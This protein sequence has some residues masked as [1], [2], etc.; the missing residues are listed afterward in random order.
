MRGRPEGVREFG[1]RRAGPAIST[2]DCY[3]KGAEGKRQGDLDVAQYLVTGF[4][5]GCSYALVGV[6]FTIIYKSY[7]ILNFAQ[8][9]FA[10]F[11]AL[12][13]AWLVTIKGVSTAVAIA[14]GLLLVAGLAVVFEVGLL[15]PLKGREGPAIIVTIAAGVL[16]TGVAGLVFGK[17]SYILPAMLP[18]EH[19]IVVLGATVVVQQVIVVLVAGVTLVLVAVFFSQTLIG[20]AMTASVDDPGLALLAGISVRKI[21]L[22]SFVLSSILT[23]LSGILV[24]PLAAVSY[25]I[26]PT[27]TVKGFAAAILGGIGNSTGAAYGGIVLGVAEALAAAL[28]PSGYKDGVAFAIILFVLLLRLFITRPLVTE[29]GH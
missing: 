1:F 22:Y 4:V 26:G 19:P 6:G 29:G 28:L 16:L 20:K 10:M 5:L 7:R 23:G 27:L 25:R 14:L 12:L 8:G 13:A 2:F 17:D 24:A 15:R 3:H 18:C 9:E 11:A 21:R